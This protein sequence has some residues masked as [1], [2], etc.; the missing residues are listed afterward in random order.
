MG[1]NILSENITLILPCAGEGKRLGLE[2]PKELYEILPHTRLI[3]FSLNQINALLNKQDKKFNSQIKVTV[4]IRPGKE[5]VVDYVRKML[6][7]INIKGVM[8]N[9]DYMEWPGSVY[10]A[11]ET[12]SEYNL[13]LLPDSNINLSEQN[14]YIN[15]NGHTLIELIFKAL[16][17]Y[18]VVFG[19]VRCSDPEILKCLGA[20]RVEDGKVTSFQDKPFESLHHFNGFWS[21]YAFKKEFG[22][23]LYNYLINSLKH[24]PQSLKDQTFYPPGAI[25]IYSH[26]DLGTWE[27]IQR[28]QKNKSQI[29]K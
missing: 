4:V 8:F 12:F 25:Q 26:Q 1:K 24:Q 21:C 27:S 2:T 17:I 22:Y 13:A 5:A 15:Q 9:D 20:L 7:E 19:W 3:D 14:P 28:F 10:S 18:K 11:K 6:P 23:F 29:I 16:S